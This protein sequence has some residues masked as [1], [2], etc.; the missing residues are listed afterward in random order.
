MLGA[1]AGNIIGSIL[2]RNNIK[3]TDFNLIN[4]KSFLKTTRF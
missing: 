1:I 4:K 3:S 2:K